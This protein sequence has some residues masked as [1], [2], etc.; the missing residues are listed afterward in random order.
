MSSRFSKLKKA[1]R[2]LLHK[3]DVDFFKMSMLFL[4]LCGMV[5]L[6][7]QMRT[8]AGYGITT[9]RNLV[10][11][12][13]KVFRHPAYIAAV[14]VLLAG[15]VVWFVLDKKRKI[16]ADVHYFSGINALSLMAYV[17]F[18]SLFFGTS[19]DLAS[20]PMFM[21]AFTVVLCLLYYIYK[22]YHRD[23]FFF[24]LE[25]AVLALLLYR[26]WNVF[27]LRGIVGKCLLCVVFAL[28]GFLLVKNASKLSSRFKRGG[29]PVK[30]TL[31]PYFV[32]LAVWALLMLVPFNSRT[33][34][35]VLSV[36][37]VQYIAFAILYTVR[38]IRE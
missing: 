17:V 3:N 9:G 33:A 18:F 10:Y 26:Y 29:K 35:L 21:L 6:L 16:N 22:R 27:T 36:M 34:A 8:S 24:S 28:L 15:S 30:P 2:P 13:Y 7:L 32:S 25:N 11:N 37:L 1:E 20:G 23:F 5:L 19:V 38:L 14:A 31:F 4:A 12:L